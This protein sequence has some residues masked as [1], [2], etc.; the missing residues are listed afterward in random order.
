MSPRGVQLL[1]INAAAA[2]ALLAAALLWQH[3]TRP[4]ADAFE[5]PETDV[6]IVPATRT[7]AVHPYDPASGLGIHDARPIPADAR[8]AVCGMYPSRFPRWAAQLILD[9]G[10][11]LFFDSPVDLFLFLAEPERFGAARDAARAAALYVSDHAGRGWVDARQAVFV[12]G[13][14][15]RG[16]MR[17]PDLPAFAD[18]AGAAAFVAEHGGRTVRFDGIDP[19]LLASLRDQNHARHTH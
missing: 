11:A 4:H 6:C 12:T 13:S 15:A 17:G 10:G 1:L 18:E 5:P 16:P 2:S 9:D 19:P 14:A 7:N 3:A 8:C